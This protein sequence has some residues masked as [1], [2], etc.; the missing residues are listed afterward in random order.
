MQRSPRAVQVNHPAA[1]SSPPINSPGKYLHYKFR[2][3]IRQIEKVALG[4]LVSESKAEVED[5]EQRHDN[6]AV[7]AWQV[8]FCRKVPRDARMIAAQKNRCRTAHNFLGSVKL[9]SNFARA[10]AAK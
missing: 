3:E 7:R 4:G 1:K 9:L 5:L 6:S 2:S 10:S 8:I